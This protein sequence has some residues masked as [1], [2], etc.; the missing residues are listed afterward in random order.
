MVEQRIL[1]KV[2]EKLMS[3]GADFAE[4]FVERKKT[5]GI[6]LENRKIERIT[7]GEKA[8]AGL[9]VVYGDR[10]YFAFSEDLGEDALYRISESL[11]LKE[12]GS[13]FFGTLSPALRQGD[14]S[15]LFGEGKVPGTLKEKVDLLLHLNDLAWKDAG[16][17]SQLMLN[18]GDQEQA[19]EIM[20]SR[21]VHI[22]D[23][24]PRVKAIAQGI[25]TR[26]GLVQS[27]FDSMG[28]LG[29]FGFIRSRD[30]DGFLLNVKDKGERL[31]LAGEAPSGTMPVVLSGEAGGTMVHEACGH[32]LEADIVK[33]GMS[34]YGGKIGEKVASDL[35]TVVDDG[36]IRGRYGSGC[37]DDEGTPTARNVLIENG[38]LKGYMSDL[39]S[40]AELGLAPSGNGRR[41]GYHALPI[42]RMTNTFI[43]SGSCSKEEVLESVQ[44]GL[45][46]RKM[47]GGQVNTA[48]GDFVFEVSEGYRIRNGKLADQVRGATLIGNGP[49]VL[50]RIDMVADDFGYSLGTCG[51]DGQG[52]PVADAQPTLRIPSLVVGGTK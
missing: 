28:A 40:A 32:G 39:L 1:E 10:T 25:F 18:Y 41:E 31:L 30:M 12:Q 45:F 37:F 23:S 33:K 21:G 47:G 49:E 8:G 48:T 42:T 50:E 43:A 2:I 26:D 44:D 19:V 36:T 46:V 22:R 20:N 38:I 16:N 27:A 13:H 4:I 7:S 34:V 9:R 17:L 11:S 29:D 24:R 51:K 5:L 6:V 35:I 52:V 15:R 3:R 14:D